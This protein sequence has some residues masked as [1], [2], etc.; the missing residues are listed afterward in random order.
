MKITFILISLFVTTNPAH[1]IIT[2]KQ[3]LIFDDYV[4]HQITAE[5]ICTQGGGSYCSNLKNDGDGICRGLGGNICINIQ[6]LAQGYC[7]IIGESYCNKVES[8][9]ISIWQA[10]VK[11]KCKEIIKN[12]VDSAQL[13]Q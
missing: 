9:D 12:L 6:N 7:S 11:S 13:V 2:A 8:S 5:K 3:C 1:A 4:A 10:K